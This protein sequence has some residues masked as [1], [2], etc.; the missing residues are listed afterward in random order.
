[1]GDSKLASKNLTE[2]LNAY[3]NALEIKPDEEYPKTKIAE[4]NSALLLRKKNWRKCIHSYIAEGDRLF[5]AKDYA[6]AKSAFTKAT[7]IKPA[8]TYPKQR[9]TEINKI[10]EEIELARRAEYNKALGEAD[11]LYN[12][13][14]FRPGY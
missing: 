9:I 5:E 7:G 6:G 12:Y 13:Q 1:M 11:K 10:V 3:Q 4:I 2:A 8:E 14:S